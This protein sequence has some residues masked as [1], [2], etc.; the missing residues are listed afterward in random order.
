MQLGLGILRLS[1]QN[2]WAMTLSELE[3]AVSGAFGPTS[4]PSPLARRE[5]SALIKRFPDN[6][7][8]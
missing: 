8:G 2:F 3:A 5:L 4:L 1:P 6:D 7:G